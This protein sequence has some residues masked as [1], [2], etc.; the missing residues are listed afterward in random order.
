M[1][2]NLIYS[3]VATELL[4]IFK[5]LEKAVKEKIPTDLENKLI[6]LKNEDYV[7]NLDK[8]KNLDE[9]DILPETRQILSMIYLKYCCSEEE[10]NEILSIKKN[11]DLEIEKIKS[12]KYSIDNIFTTDEKIEE[13]KNVEM[14]VY[15]EESSI[16]KKI[17][18]KIKEFFEKILG[19]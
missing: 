12:E 10:A 11:K 1:E 8:S 14:I 3:N 6:E 13:P 7:F 16:Y 19:K 5:Y 18:N 2:S 15:E 9:Q 17:I 4:E